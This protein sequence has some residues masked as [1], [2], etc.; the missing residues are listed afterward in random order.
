[1]KGKSNCKLCFGSGSY[2]EEADAHR[3]AGQVPCYH[4]P[5]LPKPILKKMRLEVP[6]NVFPTPEKYTIVIEATK[7]IEVNNELN[8]LIKDNERMEQTLREIMNITDDAEVLRQAMRGLG[9]PV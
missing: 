6:D 5:D 9:F 3:S 2:M 7:A 4:D 8:K 1:M